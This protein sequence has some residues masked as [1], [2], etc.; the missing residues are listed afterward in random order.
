MTE[1][2]R[3]VTTDCPAA[4]CISVAYQKQDRKQLRSSPYPAGSPVT[5][6]D[7]SKFTSVGLGG[8]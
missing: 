2:E 8:I 5:E 7:K 1:T 6:R 4:A 3:K